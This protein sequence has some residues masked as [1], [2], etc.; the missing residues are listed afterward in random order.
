MTPE[1]RTRMDDLY[2]EILRTPDPQT[3]EVKRF[4]RKLMEIR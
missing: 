1:M 3:R 4:I 2:W